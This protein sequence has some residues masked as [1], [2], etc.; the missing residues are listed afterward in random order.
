MGLF[1]RTVGIT[2][3]TLKIGMTK[4]VYNMK[5]LVFWDMVHFPRGRA[6]RG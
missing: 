3:A 2:R 6:V 5:P 4:L 1:I